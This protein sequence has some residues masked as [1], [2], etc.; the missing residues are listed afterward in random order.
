MIA[1]FQLSAL[2]NLLTIARILGVVPLVWFMLEGHYDWAFIF[3]VFAGL[4]D[5]LDGFLARRYAWQSHFGGWA[6]PFA[7]K[8]MMSASYITLTY[9]EVFPIWLT[10][11]VLGRD[12][13]IASGALM[14]R[15]LFG[16]FRAHPT[17]LSKGTTLAQLALIWFEL[18]NLSGFE[19]TETL[20]TGL[21]VCVGFMTALTLCQYVFIWGKKAVTQRRMGQG[22]S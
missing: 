3:A 1:L 21:V 17:T 22:F 16:R 19:I 15:I 11:L 14:Y 5:V 20:L 13:I 2:P 9:L 10:A 12:L 8:L 18:M 6:D 7:D 4:S